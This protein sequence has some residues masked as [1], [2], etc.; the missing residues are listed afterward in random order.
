M[1]TRRDFLQLSAAGAG[2]VGTVGPGI[3][4]HQAFPVGVQLYTVR[5]QAEKDLGAVLAHI[6]MIG[7][8]E[9]ET[10]W[11]VYTHPAK[12]LREHDRRQRV[13]R[14]QRPFRL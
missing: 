5:E 3:R 7:Y 11:N 9:V 10:Y 2:H 12:E 13:D 4:R 8:K 6:S 1:I 14:A